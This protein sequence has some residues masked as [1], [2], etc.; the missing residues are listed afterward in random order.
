MNNEIKEMV[1]IIIDNANHFQAEL[2]EG[3][4]TGNVWIGFTS[5]D[6]GKLYNLAEKWSNDNESNTND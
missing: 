5:E 3:Y 6:W 4:P 1:D 2:I